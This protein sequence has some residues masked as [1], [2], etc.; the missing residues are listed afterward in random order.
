M[1]LFNTGVTLDDARGTH[2]ENFLRQ[3]FVL[4]AVIC[5]PST[6]LLRFMSAGVRR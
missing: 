3:A 6:F 1:T 5:V 2:E 4:F